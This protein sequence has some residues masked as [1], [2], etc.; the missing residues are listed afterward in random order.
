MFYKKR[1]KRRTYQTKFNVSKVQKINKNK[2][3]PSSATSTNETDQTS[4]THQDKIYLN[5]ETNTLLSDEKKIEKLRIQW[6]QIKKLF[7]KEGVKEDHTKKKLNINKLQ[8]DPK[9]KLYLVNPH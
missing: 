1:R 3:T 9:I 8:L 4:D 2:V 7:A 5:N 6:N